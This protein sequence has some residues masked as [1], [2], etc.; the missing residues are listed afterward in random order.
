MTILQA[1]ER[2]IYKKI[3]PLMKKNGIYKL[4]IHIHFVKREKRDKKC[5][6]I[7][8]IFRLYDYHVEVRYLITNYQKY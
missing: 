2:N 4:L 1:E 8:Y 3:C 5:I 7:F 6:Y